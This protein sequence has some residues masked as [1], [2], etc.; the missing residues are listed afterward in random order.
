MLRLILRWNYYGMCL[1]WFF[2]VLKGGYFD[3]D[4][5]FLGYFKRSFNKNG[6]GN[7]LG[8]KVRGAGRSGVVPEYFGI[9]RFRVWGLGVGGRGRRKAASEKLTNVSNIISENFADPFPRLGLGL[10][11]TFDA[12]ARA[13]LCYLR[14]NPSKGWNF[15]IV[16][17]MASYQSKWTMQAMQSIFVGNFQPST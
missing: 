10:S 11:K 12:Q 8:G 5:D 17:S 14:G 13:M 4:F 7:N 9:L 6:R 1:K 3:F 2:G 15:N 16:R